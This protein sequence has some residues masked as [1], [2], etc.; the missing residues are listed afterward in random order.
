MAAPP[1]APA[2]GGN[3]SCQALGGR[4]GRGGV[5]GSGG[6]L[7]VVEIREVPES[8]MSPWKLGSKVRING[9]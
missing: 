9:L 5:G 4:R 1:K 2:H 8:W 7:K 3:Y 6:T